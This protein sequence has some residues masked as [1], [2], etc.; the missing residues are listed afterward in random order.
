MADRPDIT[1]DQH[2]EQTALARDDVTAQV[3]E[4]GSSTST[5][6]S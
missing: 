6:S 3:R 5:T 4:S 2:H 1:I